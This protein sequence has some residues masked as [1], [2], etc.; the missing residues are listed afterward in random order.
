MLTKP[1]LR[2]ILRA[3]VMANKSY[4][5]IRA[6]SLL[7]GCSYKKA[8]DA[9]LFVEHYVDEHREYFALFSEKPNSYLPI[10]ITYN[11]LT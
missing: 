1:Q 5:E 11:E 6:T 8:G 10:T 9:S 2:P 4:H 3:I 7:A